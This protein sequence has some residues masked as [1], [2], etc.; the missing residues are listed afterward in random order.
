MATKEEIAEWEKDWQTDKDPMFHSNGKNHLLVTHLDK[1]IAGRKNIKI[2]FPM[3]GKMEDMKWMYDLGHSVVGVE[4]A[5]KAVKQFFSENGLTAEVEDAP[6]VNGKLYKTKDGR[7][8][9]YCCSI[10]DF[11]KE[12]EGEFD[13]IFDR[14][15][16]AALK[17]DSRPKYADILVT[18]MSRSCNYLLNTFQFEDDDNKPVER[19]YHNYTLEE[20]NETFSKRNCFIEIV[21]V[22]AIEEHGV[23]DR[24][25]LVTRKS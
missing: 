10:F 13:G 6:A 16:Y 4:V 2:F 3:C 8:K 23:L 17:V 25:H 18:L 14:G 15:A 20:I 11:N 12:V 19:E 5:D 21:D 7:I 22:V 1:M 9:I 24:L